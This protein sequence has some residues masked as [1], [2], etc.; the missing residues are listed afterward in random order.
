MRHIERSEKPH[1]IPAFIAMGIKSSERKPDEQ[2]VCELYPHR[3]LRP[4]LIQ[5]SPEQKV[6]C[7][8]INNSTLLPNIASTNFWGQNV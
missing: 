4:I 5:A 2:L 3:H 7:N 1:R 8:F 6:A